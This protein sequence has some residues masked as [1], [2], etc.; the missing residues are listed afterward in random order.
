MPGKVL[1]NPATGDELR[2]QC[3]PMLACPKMSIRL[4]KMALK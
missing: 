4:G 1:A 3:L 2:C